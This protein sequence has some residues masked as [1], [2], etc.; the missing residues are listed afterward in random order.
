MKIYFVTTWINGEQE[1]ARVHDV[2]EL[3]ETVLGY[4]RDGIKFDVWE[5]EC[6]I[7]ES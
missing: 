7:D 5:G 3:L 1:T 6:I 4:Q 2:A